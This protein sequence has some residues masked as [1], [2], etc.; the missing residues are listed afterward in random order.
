MRVSVSP[1][2][3]EVTAGIPQSL[4]I[5]ITN[6]GTVI[7]GYSL[8]LLGADPSWVELEEDRISLF[9]DETRTLVATVTVPAGLAAGER[10][11]AVQVRELTPPER[12]T[13]EEFVLLVPEA[14]STQ[15]RID[16]VTLTAG[17]TGRFS[18]LIDNNGNTPARGW[19]AGLDA[20]NKMHYRF[21]PPV[22]D[23]APGEHAV[24]DVRARGRRPLIGQPVVRVLDVHLVE[25]SPPP[26]T[27]RNQDAPKPP[28]PEQRPATT[29][30]MVQTAVLSRGPIGLLGLLAALTVFALVLTIALSRLVGQSAADRNLALEI[31]AADG[32][33]TSSGNSGVAGT[34]RLLTTGLPVSGV[35]VNVYSAEDLVTPLASDASDAEGGYRIDGL[36]AGDYKLVFRGAGFEPLW[37]PQSLGVENAETITVEA[38]HRIAGLDVALGGTPATIGGTVLGEDVAD[39]TVSLRTPD[40]TTS[41]TPGAPGAP[42]TGAPP[43]TGGAIVDTVPV[44]ADGTF[45]F[46]NVPSPSI[47]DL[48]V[49]KKGYATSTQRVDVA[50]GEAREG[51]EINLVR[52]N[53]IISGSVTS[54]GKRIDG[55]TITATSGESSSSTVSLSSGDVG[56]FTL[57]RLPTPGVYTLVASKEGYASQTLSL[58]LADGQELTGVALSLGASSGSLSGRAL[59]SGGGPA[60]G[61]TVSVTDGV[62]S[63]ETATQSSGKVGNWKVSGLDL[64]GTYTVT[65]S[66]SDLAAQTVS[67]TLDQVG[68]I[69]PSS[70]GATVTSNGIETVMKSSTTVLEGRVTQPGND[71]VVRPVGEVTV[72][73]SSG[74]S[75]YRVTTASVPADQRGRYRVEGLPPGTYTVSVSRAGVRPTSTILQL[76]AG[77]TRDYS[78]ELAKAASV[79]GVVT[80]SDSGL[81]VGGGYLVELYR[82]GSYP[83]AVYRTT[84]TAADGSY[85]FPDVDAPEVYV[86]QVRRT[87]GAAP[88]GSGN[89]TVAA[90]Q[91]ATRNVSVTP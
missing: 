23:L 15:V 91:Q 50:A 45:T 49:T 53:G 33:G 83:G 13:V 52:G 88:I 3:I 25:G 40:T 46:A 57:R 7:G 58:T 74:S 63:V 16:P 35:A 64:P 55:V 9:P 62:R 20:E 86:V 73:L 76:A 42:A 72:E 79:R 68:T 87:Q 27:G 37:Y 66:R 36:A 17:R 1:A 31:A 8:R 71:D 59:L 47:Y 61:V 6:P 77:D 85:V 78:P 21:D 75:T 14:P 26:A 67:V 11:M 5:T 4:A 30:S 34:V 65:F 89:A 22:V 60:A 2:R 41:V 84:R 69:T 19:L 44:A 24:V 29:A 51:V 28:D 18:L 32:S 39:A 81:P 54:N 56:S 82:A 10:R 48:V 38:D 43:G 70:I 12:S 80:V 90:S